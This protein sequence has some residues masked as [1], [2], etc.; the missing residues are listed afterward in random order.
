MFF[1]ALT[2]EQHTVNCVR[3]YNMAM[4]FIGLSSGWMMLIWKANI[5]ETVV[6]M[7]LSYLYLIATWKF[8]IEQKLFNFE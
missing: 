4:V 5:Y 2:R 3:I 8:D 1:N 7:M 6:Y